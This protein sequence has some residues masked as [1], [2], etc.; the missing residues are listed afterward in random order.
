MPIQRQDSGTVTWPPAQIP[1]SS[2]S[3]QFVRPLV[4]ADG[5]QAA[6]ALAVAG[7]GW[8]VHRT[9]WNVLL[10]LERLVL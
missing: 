3:A 10:P 1:E 9:C 8:E 4:G 5:G 6:T 7:L 2:G